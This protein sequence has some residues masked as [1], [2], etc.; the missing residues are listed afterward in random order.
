MDSEVWMRQG[1]KKPRLSGEEHMAVVEEF[2]LAAKEKWP[3][4]L[5]QFEDFQT[6]K[7]FA[8]L[9]KFRNKFLCFNGK[10]LKHAARYS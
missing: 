7:A 8:I 2:C 9:E 4:C 1:N 5:I 10:V 6:D 3:D